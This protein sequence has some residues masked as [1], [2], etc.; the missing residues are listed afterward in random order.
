MLKWNFIRLFILFGVIIFIFSFVGCGR[1]NEASLNNND[2]PKTEGDKLNS[3]Y[4]DDTPLNNTN[5]AQDDGDQQ[6]QPDGETDEWK[7]LFAENFEGKVS[8]TADHYMQNP[9]LSWSYSLEVTVDNESIFI[10][11][12]L[13]KQSPS[14]DPPAFSYGT[15]AIIDQDILRQLSESQN[16][17]QMYEE[18]EKE[19]SAI[20]KKLEESKSCYILETD[21]DTK[22]GKKIVVYKVDDAFYF[23]N[24]YESGHVLRI[25]RAVVE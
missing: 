3:G 23:V 16:P 25:H 9:A 12:I 24:F 21:T 2:E 15:M 4:I 6:S 10:N 1:G 17:D 18:L 11:D 8:F 22:L 19:A 20:L 5:D 14:F 13:Y 7:Q